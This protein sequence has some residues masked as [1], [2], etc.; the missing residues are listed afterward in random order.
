MT[1]EI[2]FNPSLSAAIAAQ[3]TATNDQPHI[4]AEKSVPPLHGGENVTVTSGAATDLEKLVARLKSEDDDTRLNLAQMRLGAVMSALDIMNVK[5]SQE[6]SDA[7]ATISEQQQVKETL[8]KELSAICAEYGIDAD[9]NASAVMAAKI[10]S[11]EKAVERAV[12]EGKDHNEAVAKAKEQL[13]HDQ[14]ELDRLENAEVKD[15]AAIAAARNAVETSQGNY[16]A[17]AALA[18]GDTKK[19][20]DAK[21]ALAK[22]QADAEKIPVLQANIADASAKIAAASAIL[23]NDKMN[24]IAAAL[25]KA[26]ESLATPTDHSSDAERQKEEKKE[27]A[28]DPFNAIQ[29][30][31]DKIDDLIL[32]K[33]EENQL[34][35]A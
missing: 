26:A 6:Q 22:A 18:A 30:A 25:N 3:E 4:Q 33:I 31:L 9:D 14:A 28:L 29:A 32:N 34:L 2:K 35:K 23:S 20:A 7:F 21:S 24:E 16:N 17:A 5:L 19:I 15:E 27:I 8:E 13:E 12:Q 1:T 11:L 10:E